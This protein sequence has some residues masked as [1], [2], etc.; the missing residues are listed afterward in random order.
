MKR[1]DGTEEKRG[2][3]RGRKRSSKRIFTLRLFLKKL[4]FSKK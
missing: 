4:H 3:N 1:D 2:R